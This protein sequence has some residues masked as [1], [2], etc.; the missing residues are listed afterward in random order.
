MNQQGTDRYLTKG[1]LPQIIEV[2]TLYMRD[3][4]IKPVL[5]HDTNKVPPLLT[6]FILLYFGMQ[7]P[8]H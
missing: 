7:H 3:T 2:I 5:G 4:V 6:L 1:R 8:W